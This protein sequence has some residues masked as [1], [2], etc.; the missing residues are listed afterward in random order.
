MDS[1]TLCES[2]GPK[3]GN[4]LMR[5]HWDA[6]VTW[7]LKSTLRDLLNARSLLS[8]YLLVTGPIVLMAPTSDA[9]K[10]LLRNI[11]FKI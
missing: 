2:L 7:S 6:W 10:E 3:E 1:Y 11:N 5:A 9:W 4:K 8:D